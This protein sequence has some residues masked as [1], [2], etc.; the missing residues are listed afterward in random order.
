M[1]EIEEKAEQLLT[2]GRFFNPIEAQIAAGLLE[3]EGIPV[4][5]LSINHVSVYWLMANA[6]GGIQLQVPAGLAE[7]AQQILAEQESEAGTGDDLCPKC[8]SPS[9][10]ARSNTWRISVL[11]VHLIA[12]PLPWRRARRRC[13]ACRHEWS[14]VENARAQ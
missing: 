11:A 9:E 3:S 8:G 13:Q 1:S 6:L 14:E 2:V 12:V 7:K 5:L 4:V 10:P